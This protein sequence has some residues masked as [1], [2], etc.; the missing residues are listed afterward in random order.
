MIDTLLIT[1]RNE[2]AE[3]ILGESERAGRLKKTLDKR[4]PVA[5]LRHHLGDEG[6]ASK[7]HRN[8]TVLKI[9]LVP[10][11]E[12]QLDVSRDSLSCFGSQLAAKY[13]RRTSALTTLSACTHVA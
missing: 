10:C 3:S 9:L 7:N 11:R 6:D 8:C 4:M 12:Y 13:Q 2:Y 5:E 1:V